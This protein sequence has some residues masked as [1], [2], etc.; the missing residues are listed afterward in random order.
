[1][2]KKNHDDYQLY[3]SD[4]MNNDTDFIPLISDEEEDVIINADVPDTLPILPLKNTVLF[5]GV[6]LPITVGREKSLNLV[7]EAYK[8]EKII[9]T[10]CQRDPETDDPSLEDI[11]EVGTVAQILKIL[12]MPDGGTSII[13]QGKRRFR[14]NEMVKPDPYLVA[15]ISTLD[16]VK[17]KSG[18]QEYEALVGSL[19]DISLKIIKLSSNIP[20]E[21]S[22]AVKNIESSTFLINFISSNSDMEPEDKQKLLNEDNLKKRAKNLLEHLVK[23]VQMLELKSDIQAKA[24]MDIEQQQR[25]YLLHQQMKTIQDE[26]G[27]NPMEQEIE[28]LKKKARKKKWNKEVEETFQKEVEKLHRLNPSTG[29]YSVQVNYLQTLLELPWNEYTKDSFDLK[30]AGRVLDKD[31]YGLEKVKDRILEHLAVLKLKGDL[32]AP[33]LCLYGPPGVGKTSLGKSI[34]RAIGR[35]Y[36]RMSL[37]G[38]HDEAEIRGHRKTYIGAMPGRIVQNLKKV[39]SSNPVFV[40]DEIDKVGRSFQGDPASALLEVLDPEQNANFYDNFLELE[41]DLSNILFI[42][43]ANTLDTI[44]PALRDRMEIIDVSGYIMEEK[45]QIAKRHLIPKQLADHGVKSS[46]VTFSKSILEHVIEHYTRESGVRALDKNLA[47]IARN[48]AKRIALGESFAK[49]LT[50]ESIHEILGLPRFI[51]DRYQGNE[52][53]G[54]VTGLAWTAVGGDI[55]FVET[56][57]SAGKGKLTITGNLGEVMKESGI[58]ALEYLKAHASYLGLSPDVF[59]QWNYHIH[60]P[61]GAIPKDGPS[62]GITM[63]TSLASA[64]T[65]RKVKKGVAMTGEITLRGKVLPVGGIKEKILAAKRAGIRDIILSKENEKDI[66][67]I[68][69]MYIKGLNF[70]YVEDIKQVLDFA[71]LKDKVKDAVKIA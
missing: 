15:N 50:K 9:G 60:V 61:E 1:M 65:Q 44:H 53:A 52:Y 6:V 37:G 55:L 35:K 45:V 68:K 4:P 28:E 69:D 8:K 14:I 21:A 33:I 13:I 67:E 30:K 58:I 3:L 18:D 41:Y 62:A 38:L 32:K 12:E 56:S 2:G 7:K 47:K 48:L 10:V 43:T 16:E 22:F 24:K 49:G 17:P 57:L 31:H 54:V 25:E 59:D 11:Y 36:I 40:L 66:V 5:P 39:K 23:E 34:A 42:A 27:G 29:E 71:L 46:Q 19:K 26:L 70:H 63:L 20:V 64:F 51:K